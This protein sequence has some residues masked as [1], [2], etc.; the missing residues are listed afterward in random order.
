MEISCRN[1]NWSWPSGDGG[2]DMFVCHECGNDNSE[3]YKGGIIQAFNTIVDS[4][5][6]GLI[7]DEILIKASISVR[8][9]TNWTPPEKFGLIKAKTFNDFLSGEEPNQELFKALVEGETKVK[10]GIMYV[11]KKTKSGQLDWRRATK[12]PK[13]VKTPKNYDDF[14]TDLT[15][16]KKVGKTLGGSTGAVLVEDPDTGKKFVMKKGASPEHVQDE[17]TAT[18]IYDELGVTVPKMQLYNDDTILSEYMENTVDA[19]S[20]LDDNLRKEIMKGFVADCLLANWDAYKND[21]ILVNKDD[22][23]VYRVDN[24]GSLRF[25][26]QGRDKG[27]DFGDEVNE[28][29]SMVSHN[30]QITGK[31]TQVEINT[32]I[33]DVLSKEKA[34]LGHIK[35]K[36]L[37]LKMAK[38]FFDLRARMDDTDYS[39]L[40]PYREFED[41][42]IKKALKKAGGHI[43]NQDSKVGWK[44]LSELC[45]MRGFD[46]TPEVINS[47][48]FDKL[49]AE[50]DSRLLQRGVTG[51]GGLN[52]QSVKKDF[53]DNQDCFYGRY[54][55]YGAGIYAA[56]NEQKSNPPPPNADYQIAYDYAGYD[57]DAIIDICLDKDAKVID[58]QELDT[59]MNDEFFGEEFKEKKQEY[60][61]LRVE[62]DALQDKA[63]NIEKTI[64]DDTKEEMGWNDKVLNAL[65]SRADIVYADPEVH[66]FGKVKRYYA[67]LV[68][69]LGAVVEEHDNGNAISIELP[70]SGDKFI[71]SETVAGRSLKQKNEYSKPYN[72]HYSRLRDFVVKEHYGKIN[73]EIEQRIKNSDLIDKVKQE[74]KDAQQKL[75]AVADEVNNL[76]GVG[77]STL[78]EVMLEIA[79]RP[80][81]EY[82]GFYA[83]I[84][85]YDAIIQKNGWGGS[86]DFAVILNR[87]KC[88]V[89]KFK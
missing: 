83:A 74:A 64:A 8:E 67:T 37:K 32:Q 48:D 24:G 41:A 10:S 28:L 49:V 39:K 33:K 29:E 54:G 51:Y 79:K 3:F 18:Q 14:P 2:H 12:Q 31:I 87:G 75:K 59:M 89:R 43:T 61:D 9:K 47:A 38:R 80:N 71:M 65:N 36:D 22:G 69:Q 21:N 30:L 73:K 25:S 4:N 84:K 19:N 63:D 76:R 44:F 46:A 15:K 42:D 27:D 7:P 81:G 70:L 88:K 58:A 55:M 35:D 23:M 26:A 1:C 45:K 40:D 5:S 56:V 86:T 50:K 53:T 11:V 77:S 34:V 82:R 20:V 66:S 60:D 68:G 6:K 52:A 16:L 72:Y 78:D 62:V 17:Y 85:G 57:S 13:K